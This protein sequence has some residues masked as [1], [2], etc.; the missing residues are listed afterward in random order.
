MPGPPPDFVAAPCKTSMALLR[1]WRGSSLW[2]L[3]CYC[4]G[5]TFRPSGNDRGPVQVALRPSGTIHSGTACNS[6]FSMTAMPPADVQGLPSGVRRPH[7]HPPL[8]WSPCRRLWTRATTLPASLGGPHVRLTECPT[9]SHAGFLTQKDC[10]A[11]LRG[12][13]SMPS[14]AKECSSSGLL[15]HLLL[16]LGTS[17]DAG[18]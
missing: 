9:P 13:S 15:P 5:K 11:W 3:S 7:R 4:A 14:A 17:E 1:A 8:L 16:V 12:T 6:T 2:W 18:G 10:I